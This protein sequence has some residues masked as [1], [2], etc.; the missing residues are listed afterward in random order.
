MGANVPAPPN[1]IGVTKKSSNS[2]LNSRWNAFK[3]CPP[4]S[5]RTGT[6]RR[7]RPNGIRSPKSMVASS[8]CAQKYHT[9]EERWIGSELSP[10]EEILLVPAFLQR[11]WQQAP[12]QK[13]GPEAAPYPGQPAA[14]AV[15]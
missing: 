11:S 5:R 9:T 4:R 6:L 1:S 8:T 2:R 10:L 14:H 3:G 15:R 13:G 12:P 7:S